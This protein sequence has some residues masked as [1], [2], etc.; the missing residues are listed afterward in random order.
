MIFLRVGKLSNVTFNF[1]EKFPRFTFRRH[2]T[3]FT[4]Y[5]FEC[6]RVK[7]C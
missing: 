3:N 4:V 6:P 2:G 5:N 7:K 1:I